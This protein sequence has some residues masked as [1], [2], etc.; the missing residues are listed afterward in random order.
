MLFH[1]AA[2]ERGLDYPGYDMQLQVSCRIGET[3]TEADIL[4]EKAL[5]SAASICGLGHPAL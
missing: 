4:S 2:S 5:C 1:P 3:V